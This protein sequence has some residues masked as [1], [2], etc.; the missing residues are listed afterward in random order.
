MKLN[1]TRNKLK[2]N[3]FR[4][5]NPVSSATSSI[6]G[7]EVWIDEVSNGTSISFF[8]QG[9]CVDGEFKVSGREPNRPDGYDYW[10]SIF[11]CNLSEAIRLSRAS[12]EKK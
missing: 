5:Q 3:G 7:T 11:T 2:K 6:R 10:S 9:E 1:R 4:P 12:L 8:S